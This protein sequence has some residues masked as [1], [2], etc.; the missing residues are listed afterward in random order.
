MLDTLTSFCYLWAL[1]MAPTFADPGLLVYSRR[2]QIIIRFEMVLFNLGNNVVVRAF[3]L[4][5]GGIRLE[6]LSTHH[7]WAL[8]SA[9]SLAYSYGQCQK[10]T[11]LAERWTVRHLWPW[12]SHFETT[13]SRPSLLD[14]LGI[15]SCSGEIVTGKGRRLRKAKLPVR[16]APG[17]I[18]EINF[19]IFQIQILVLE[20]SEREMLISP[21]PRGARRISS[22]AF[23]SRRLFRILSPHCKLW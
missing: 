15:I 21:L 6:F 23:L 22:C 10:I 1:D 19:Q 13:A 20:R 11:Q 8:K 7:C 17:G 14:Q 2:K 4:Y 9:S 5:W 18:G 16:R 3:G 12:A